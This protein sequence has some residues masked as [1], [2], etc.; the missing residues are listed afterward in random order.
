MTRRE[1][2][3][4]SI[5]EMGGDKYRLR[6]FIGNDPVTSR[7]RYAS[8]TLKARNITAARKALVAFV[9]EHEGQVLNSTATVKVVL[10]E[11]VK[12]LETK[13]RAYRTIDEANRIS[14]SVINPVLGHI[15][16][17]DLEGRHIDQLIRN[18]GHLKPATVRRYIAVLSAALGFAMQQGWIDRNPMVRASLP[19]QEQKSLLMP[20]QAELV[21]VIQSV[22][23]GMYQ[24]ALTLAVFT[25]ARRGELCG[26]RWSDI[27]GEALWIRRSIYRYE[28]DSIAKSTKGNRERR[29]MLSEQAK[30]ALYLWALECMQVAEAAGI[31]M[32]DDPYILSKWPD[33]SQP[34]NPDT[35]TD[36]VSKAARA[37]GWAHIH[38]HSF[39]HYGATQ[40]LAQGMNARDAAEILGHADGGT[41]LLNT[42]AH[43]TTERQKAAGAILGNLLTLPETQNAPDH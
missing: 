14:E 1:K 28:G 9:V 41:L 30:Q 38:L 26:L 7:P 42:Y 18:H 35:L 37:H 32:A 15:P 27:D 13:R 29:V 8:T 33:S 6:C 34:V 21:T 10:G 22:P 19:E 11:Y 25:A 36:V 4:G 20:T 43:P 12:S 2:G 39:R 3:S 17:G 16:V 5:T 23:A 31:T 40:M 24:T